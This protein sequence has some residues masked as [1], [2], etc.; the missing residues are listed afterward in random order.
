MDLHASHQSEKYQHF[1]AKTYLQRRFVAPNG[2]ID[3]ERGVQP[4][5]LQCYH[6]FYQTFHSSW[7]PTKARLLE[8]GGGPVIYPLISA[9]PYFADI[10]FADFSKPNL[11]QV[12]LWVNKDAEAHDWTP[13][14]N[15]IVG[16][17]EGKV[18]ESQSRV[19]SLR[20][21]IK[22]I[23]TCDILKED[24]NG[25]LDIGDRFEWFDVISF[26][27]C[28]EVVCKTIESYQE[29]LL[30]LCKLV[31]PQGYLTSLIS[32]EESWY[33]N[34]EEKMFNLGLTFE[35][36][37]SSFKQAGFSVEFSDVFPIP[38]EAQNILND[39]KAIAFVVGRKTNSK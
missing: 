28:C 22:T 15:H 11:E 31:R 36:V 25:I 18:G 8:L 2:I 7:D 21:K 24:P 13:Y 3:E 30:R 20:S 33:I 1:N 27:F 10:T 16:S 26:N 5:Y 19:T 6:H 39:C 29:T 4:F 17:L 35:N 37:T 12:E 38:N 32:L 14:F 34:G 23:V 9:A